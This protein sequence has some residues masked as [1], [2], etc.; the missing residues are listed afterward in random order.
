MGDGLLRLS[1]QQRER[2]LEAWR[3]AAGELISAKF[4]PASGA[5]T[6][7]FRDLVWRREEGLDRR[8]LVERAAA[9][10]L[11]AK[12]VLG[13]LDELDRFA[14]RDRLAEAVAA[15]GTDLETAR[16]SSPQPILDALLGADGLGYASTPKGLIEFHAYPGGPRKAVEEHLVEGLGYLLADGTG[17]GRFHFTVSPEHREPFRRVC[18]AFAERLVA[19]SEGPGG[20]KIDLSFSVQSPAT[21]TLAVDADGRPFREDDGRL[22]LRPGGHGALIGNLGAITADVVFVKNIDNI[23]PERSQPEVSHWKRVLAGF[24]I[25][26]RNEI[27]ATVRALRQGREGAERAADRLLSGPLGHVLPDGSPGVE[28]RLRRI[29]ALD[30]P[31]RVC[32]MVV[33][34]GEPGGGPFWVRGEDGTVSRQIVEPGQ[35]DHD[36]PRQEAAWTASTHFNPVDVVASLRAPD[37][38]AYDLERFV[39]PRAVFITKKTHLGRPLQVLERPGL[40]NGAMAGWNTVFVEVPAATFAPVKTVLDLLRPAHRT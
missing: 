13:F 35:V 15:R 16:E 25:E 33:N 5:A 36:D 9:G 32:G 17:T 6:R 28:D 3:V 31:L 20:L 2:Y 39:D 37:G 27:H 24:L 1:A 22:L 30:R 21:D 4:V 34:E 26:L 19:T 8:A 38:A 18:A 10:S 12:G 23:V 11:A 7:M 14:F 40:W 29:E